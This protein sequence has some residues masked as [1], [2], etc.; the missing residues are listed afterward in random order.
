V[1]GTNDVISGANMA[2]FVVATAIADGTKINQLHLDLYK[3]RQ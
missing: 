1:A 3:R 2:A